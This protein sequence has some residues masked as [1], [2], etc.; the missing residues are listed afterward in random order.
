[1]FS[2]DD[3]GQ[4]TSFAATAVAVAVGT[5]CFSGLL[6]WVVGQPEPRSVL[7]RAG[8]MVLE[9]LRLRLYRLRAGEWKRKVRKW[10]R[11]VGEWTRKVKE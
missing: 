2:W 11:T 5:Y 3:P 8:R 6:V 7:P 1:M 9:W 10:K 4:K